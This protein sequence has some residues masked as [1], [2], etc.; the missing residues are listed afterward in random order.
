MFNVIHL[1]HVMSLC[2]DERK[3][4]DRLSQACN[5]Y[6]WIQGAGETLTLVI[7]M[8]WARGSSDCSPP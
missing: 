1:P 3:A 5:A 7:T 6:N 8:D 4:R 2:S